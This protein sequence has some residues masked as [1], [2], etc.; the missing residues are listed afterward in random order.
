MNPRSR[1]IPVAVAAAL[2]LLLASATESRAA[3]VAPYEIAWMEA[4]ILASIPSGLVSRPTVT[5]RSPAEAG[6][7]S[8]VA[9]YLPEM[10][11]VWL[12]RDEPGGCHCLLIHQFLHAIHHQIRQGEGFLT[13]DEP[14]AV[15]AWVTAKMGWR[16]GSNAC[17]FSPRPHDPA[18]QLERSASIE[19]GAGSRGAR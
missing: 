2:T 12:F 19:P 4:V 11:E 14:E 17:R 1:S 9:E 10:N 18:V 6:S 3:A 16:A 5:F 8:D 13:G 15:E 7:D